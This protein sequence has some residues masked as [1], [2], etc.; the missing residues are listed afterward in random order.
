MGTP[1]G[2]EPR[3]VYHPPS[4]TIAGANVKSYE[5]MAESATRDLQGFWAVQ[6]EE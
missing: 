3:S 5:E 4:E 6:A 2:H 1:D